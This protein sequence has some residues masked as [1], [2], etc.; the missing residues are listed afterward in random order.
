M[1]MVALIFSGALLYAT[2][3]L[4]NDLDDLGASRENEATQEYL[5]M[6]KNIASVAASGQRW[7]LSVNSRE[8]NACHTC[9]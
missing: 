5:E 8:R 7:Q 1:L 9:H 2:S 6:T 3:R 4:P